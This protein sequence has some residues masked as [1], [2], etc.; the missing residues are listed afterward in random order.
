MGHI[1]THRQAGSEACLLREYVVP[2]ATTQSYLSLDSALPL[3]HATSSL[4][5]FT[6]AEQSSAGLVLHIDIIYSGDVAQGSA[7]HYPGLDLVCGEKLEL[8]FVGGSS[9]VLFAGTQI[10]HEPPR[11]R[12]SSFQR[13]TQGLHDL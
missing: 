3:G 2:T 12:V 6:M 13:R 5:H 4:V 11:R 1:P 7:P 10:L 8:M 9:G